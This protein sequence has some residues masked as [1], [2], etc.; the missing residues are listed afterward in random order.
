MPALPAYLTEALWDNLFPLIPQRQDCHPLGC[1]R[2]RVADRLVFD[3]LLVLL[4][5][6]CS[7]QQASDKDCSATTLRRR[8]KEWSNLGIGEDLEVLALT[9]YDQR[10]G[11]ALSHISIDGCI[12]KAP[13]G[14]E[15]AGKSPV[16][17]GKLGM[18]KSVAVDANG[19]PLA[20]EIAPA[21]VPDSYLLSPTLA[22]VERLGLLVNNATLHLDKGYRGS[23]V[24][25]VLDGFD[26]KGKISEVWGEDRRRWV[27]ERTNSWHNRFLRLSRCTEVT[28]LAVEFFVALAN[29][30][31]VLRS[32][33]RRTKEIN[34]RRKLRRQEG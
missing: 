12:T 14:G 27:V 32:Y 25:A 23:R 29:A 7:Y 8:R 17:R 33:H 21:N 15:V 18:K 11:L 5:S 6:G 2:P 31:I 19:I 1:H 34:L 22:K 3:R 10:F 20:V 26:V 13:S 28:R 16:D 9:K 24:K 30:I 4:T